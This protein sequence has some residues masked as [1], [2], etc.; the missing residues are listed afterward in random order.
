LRRHLGEIDKIAFLLPF[1]WGSA[2]TNGG[3]RPLI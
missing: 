3:L 1:F 2:G